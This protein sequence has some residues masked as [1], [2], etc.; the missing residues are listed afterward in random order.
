MKVTANNYVKEES[1]EGFNLEERKDSN[2][3]DLSDEI[4]DISPDRSFRLSQSPNS[5]SSI[6][7]AEKSY[8]KMRSRVH[9]PPKFQRSI[10]SQSQQQ[11]KRRSLGNLPGNS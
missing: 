2:L 11:L 5:V 1:K 8:D 4:K 3:S 9:K 7:N 6:F 10:G